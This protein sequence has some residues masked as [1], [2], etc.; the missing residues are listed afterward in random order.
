MVAR[1]C[2]WVAVS[3]GASVV[4]P[5]WLPSVLVWMAEWQQQEVAGWRWPPAH[6][7]PVPTVV[8]Q[9]ANRH[10]SVVASDVPI[11][12]LVQ[13]LEELLELGQM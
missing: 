13:A 9:E 4:S 1:A 8:V 5:V 11:D 3:S 7:A 12:A 6:V 10:A 2:V